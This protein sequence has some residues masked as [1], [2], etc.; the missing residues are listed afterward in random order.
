MNSQCQLFFLKDRIKRFRCIGKRSKLGLT[1]QRPMWSMANQENEIWVG[2]LAW[3]W[4]LWSEYSGPS[5]W[6]LQVRPGRFQSKTMDRLQLTETL[7]VEGMIFVF[8][9]FIWALP[10]KNAFLLI[11]SNLIESSASFSIS[12]SKKDWFVVVSFLKDVV[13]FFSVEFIKLLWLF[14]T[15]LLK[16]AVEKNNNTSNL[17]FIDFNLSVIFVW[18]TSSKYVFKNN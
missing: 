4:N 13:S 15:E 5:A 17:C 10:Y 14:P 2:W 1:S 8:W 3:R 6:K 7:N 18:L 9:Y 11:T 12:A 16:Q